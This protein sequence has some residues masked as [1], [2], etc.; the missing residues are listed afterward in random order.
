MLAVGRPVSQSTLEPTAK[1]RVLSPGARQ[2]KKEKQQRQYAQ[3]SEGDLEWQRLHKVRLDYARFLR[4]A[5]AG[6]VRIPEDYYDSW[7]GL[8][9]PPGKHV[10]MRSTSTT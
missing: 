7:K 5:H 8:W 6:Y 2:R 3:K 10:S 1:P 4:L 9:T